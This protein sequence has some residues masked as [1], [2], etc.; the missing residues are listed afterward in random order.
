MDDPYDLERFVEAQE[1]GGTYHTAVRE[2]RNSRKETH[3]MWF[4]LPQVAG[5]G[6]SGM[7]RRYAISGLPEARAYVGHP[8]LGLRL[9]ECAHILDDLP[10]SDAV[11]IFGRLD[12]RKL[13]SSMTLFSLADPDRPVFR[14]VLDRYFAGQVDDGTITRL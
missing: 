5:L 9:E 7:A 2:L 1:A 10:G 4:V 6:Q 12:A 11:G 13:Q 14:N 8:V 3:W